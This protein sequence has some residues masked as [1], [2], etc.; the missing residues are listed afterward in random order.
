MKILTI[1]HIKFN[2]I[3]F[4]FRF[5]KLIILSYFR[6][7]GVFHQKYLNSEIVIRSSLQ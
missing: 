5:E 1:F 3:N 7:D 6:V 4:K 2:F